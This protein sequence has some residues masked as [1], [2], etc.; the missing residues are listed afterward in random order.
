MSPAKGQGSGEVGYIDDLNPGSVATLRWYTRSVQDLEC[1]GSQA[2][3]PTELC[4]MRS[5]FRKSDIP[6][7]DAG[8][9]PGKTSGIAVH[10]SKQPRESRPV[11][12]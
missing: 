10:P 12:A 6:G 8:S 2:N 1:G 3:P 4:A 7:K 9:L 11:P 5:R